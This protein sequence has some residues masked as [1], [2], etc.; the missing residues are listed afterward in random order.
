MKKKTAR[1]LFLPLGL[2]MLL[3]PAFAAGPQQAGGVGLEEH[4][5]GTVPADVSFLDDA[6]KVVRVGDVLGRP[7]ILSLV[8]GNCD[9]ICPEVLGGLAQA[10]PKIG[11]QPG[12]D[13]RL[14]TLSI[15]E[16]DTPAGAA[17]MKKNYISAIEAPFPAEQW[18]FLTGTAP[19]IRRMTDALGVHFRT[20]M[21]GFVLPAVLVILAP[22]GTISRY[23]YVE[24]FLYGVVYPV[25]FSG[26][27]LRESLARAD[28]GEI[29][30]DSTRN[31]LLAF[32][33]EPGQY[34]A[35]FGMLKVAGTAA[36]MCLGALFL[37]LGL[38][39]TRPGRRQS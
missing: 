39:G 4:L 19:D 26:V 13:Y 31:V 34:D 37:Y 8:Y 6:G 11:L 25:R 9:H 5:G 17:E 3:A 30:R 12:R 7:V 15:D 32:P 27:E 29:T 16:N 38:A 1:I 28:R 22:D 36:L 20:E 10:I 35:F 24:K 33:H 14:I 21:H 2:C 18:D 23:V